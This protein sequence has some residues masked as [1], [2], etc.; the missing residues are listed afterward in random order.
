MQIAVNGLNIH[1]ERMG[2]GR[3]VLLLHGWGAN[4][5]VMRSIAQYL[6]AIGREAVSLDFPGF[7]KS[8]APAE[9]WGIPEYARFTRA[10]VEAL[11]IRGADVVAHSFGGR[12]TIY[13]AAEEAKLFGRLVLVDAAGIRPKRSLK[14]YLKVYSYKIGKRLA[15][16][17]F[18][19]RIFK[20][21]ERQKNA[22]SADYRALSGTMR[23]TFVKVVNHDL[24]PLLRRIAN[25]VLLVW[26]RE[27]KETP[28]YMAERMEREIPNCGLAVIENAG[29][30][31]FLDQ[32]ARFC[33]IIKVLLEDRS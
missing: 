7:G 25:E 24:S 17:G 14:Y 5:D 23:A 8:D 9:P 33:S 10:F 29:H 1:Y 20:L 26:G 12:V 16:I 13:L 15:K 22:G 18:L 27:D 3:P 28:M 2:K 11:D 30:F 21:S 31:S 32:Y 6:A 4:T 19:D